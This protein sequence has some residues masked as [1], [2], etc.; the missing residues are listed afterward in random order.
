M[1]DNP[2]ISRRFSKKSPMSQSHILLLLRTWLSH[3]STWVNT[4]FFLLPVHQCINQ[5]CCLFCFFC[6]D[7]SVNFSET[8]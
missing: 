6:W 7:I 8:F 5:Y 1:K 4:S 2:F 3:N